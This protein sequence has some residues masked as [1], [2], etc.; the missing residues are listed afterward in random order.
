MASA[1]A[2][3]ARRYPLLKLKLGGEGDETR[4]AAIRRAVPEARLIADANEAWAPD[5]VARR[6]KAAAAARRRADRA[7]AA[8]GR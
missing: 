7:A 5:D 4:L 2:A 6:L 8:R 3:A 1:A